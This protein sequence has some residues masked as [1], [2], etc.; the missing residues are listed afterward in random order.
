M[1]QLKR[2]LSLFTRRGRFSCGHVAR[3]SGK[4]ENEGGPLIWNM[5]P[6]EAAGS[7]CPNCAIEK[8]ISCCF[9]GKQIYP[10]SPVAL[11]GK[12]SGGINWEK[13]TKVG[14]NAIGC[15]NMDC[16]P[17]GGFFAGYWTTEGF[18][19]YSWKERGA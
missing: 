4:T 17:S 12:D 5:S 8:A 18:R 14:D 19:H 15:L 9:C 11:Y 3:L 10:G 1:V 2:I 6:W 16:C 7:V 13:A